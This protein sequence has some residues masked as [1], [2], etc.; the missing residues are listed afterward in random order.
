MALFF[1]LGMFVLALAF[2]FWQLRDVAKAR[3]QTAAAKLAEQQAAERAQAHTHADAHAQA[4]DT[5]PNEGRQDT[6]SG[7]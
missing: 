1:E 2:G 5:P 7:T 3:E 6:A 4:A